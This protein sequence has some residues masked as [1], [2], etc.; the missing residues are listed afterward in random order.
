MVVRAGQHGFDNFSVTPV[1]GVSAQTI[2]YTYDPLYRLTN[3]NYSTSSVFTYTYDAVGNR[4]SQTITS[5][6]VYTYDDANRL[7]N[8]G[9]VAFTWDANGNLVNDG[10]FTYTYDTANRLSTVTGSGLTASYAYNGMGNRM[11][12]V[13]GGI[14]TTYTLDLNAGLVQV[15]ADSSANTYL[16][17]NGWIAQFAGSTASYFLAD[18]L[19]SVRQLANASGAVTLAKGYQPFGTMLSSNGTGA[20]MYGFTGEVTDNTGLVYLRAR[21]YAPGHGRF[22]TRDPWQGSVYRPLSLNKWSY[23]EGN[24]IRFT[25]PAGLFPTRSDVA[26]GNA[27]FT[28]KCGWIDWKH[29][30]NSAFR[31]LQLLGDFRHAET[32]YQRSPYDFGDYHYWTDNWAINFSIQLGAFGIEVPLFSRFAM[33]PNSR[34]SGSWRERIAVSIFMDAN[35]QFEETQGLIGLRGSHFSEEDLTSDII[36]FYSGL[37]MFNGWTQDTNYWRIYIR[38]VCRAVNVDSSTTNSLLVFDETYGAAGL[39][40]APNARSGWRYWTPRVMP[41]SGNCDSGLCLGSNAREWPGLFSSLTVQRMSPQFNG[42]WWWRNSTGILPVDGEL[43]PIGHPRVY[44]TINPTPPP[45]PIP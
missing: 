16:Y 24:P 5:T 11:R 31:G 40:E 12:Q 43:D 26:I 20:S 1:G 8:A 19:G 2:N 3:A 42:D 18:H 27:E 41:L 29:W 28:C 10:V 35:E 15:L 37:R 32:H 39:E 34:V 13:T 33:I 14:T 30:Y 38:T 45:F 7:T 22:L 23:V 21:Y 44:R 6:M 9:G 17:G 4:L 36:G 25:D